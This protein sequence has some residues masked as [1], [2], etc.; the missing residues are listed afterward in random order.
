MYPSQPEL[1]KA[2]ASDTETPFLNLH[3]S[4]SNGV[5]LFHQKIMI[6]VT[7]LILI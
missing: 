4:I 6:S 3:L 2:N 7:I 5:L 1:N